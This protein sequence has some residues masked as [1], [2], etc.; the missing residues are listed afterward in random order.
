V[1]RDCSELDRV[2]AEYEMQVVTAQVDGM[3]IAKIT[4][5]GVERTAAAL[6][7]ALTHELEIR[8]QALSAE[9]QRIFGDTLIEEISEHLRQRI[10]GVRATVKAI[11]DKLAKCP[12]GSG[13]TVSLSWDPGEL[14][15]IDMTP[16]VSLIAGRSIA[17]LRSDQRAT[18]VEFFRRRIDEARERHVAD[19]D[20]EHATAAYLMEAFDYRT[21]F[22]FD[23]Y[24]R[25]LQGRREKLTSS[26]HGTGSGGEQ[27]VLMH[28]PLFAAAAALYDSARLGIAPRLIA[29]DEAL[30]GI[31]EQ[32]RPH[33]LR[34]TVELD[35]DVF[36]TAYEIKPYYPTIPRISVYVLH[37]VNGEWG[38]FAEWFEWDGVDLHQRDLEDPQL[39]VV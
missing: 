33:V 15:S 18:L 1:Q 31:D 2:L 30:S 22:A 25:D 26:R 5:G 39:Q 20:G 11:N 17:A 24:Q 6:A 19:A 37:R 3:T 38:V 8:E 28:M 13:R 4:E 21:W 16:I 29:L 23:L 12:T 14:D 10:T 36:L 9:Q 34:V 32:T 35:L 27:A 7:D